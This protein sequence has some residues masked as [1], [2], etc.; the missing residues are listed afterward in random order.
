[1]PRLIQVNR[2]ILRRMKATLSIIFFLLVCIP[3]M[4]Q[5][6]GTCAVRWEPDEMVCKG[7]S[8][9]AHL[10]STGDLYILT[11][12]PAN[13]ELIVVNPDGTRT[14]P[15]TLGDPPPL[16]TDVLRLDDDRALLM[17]P[18]DADTGKIS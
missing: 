15:I 2:G 12:T 18:L 7:C 4:A 9:T 16:A 11:H 14:Y 10:Q 13:T 3:A 17:V 5:S 6:E 1:M 8:A